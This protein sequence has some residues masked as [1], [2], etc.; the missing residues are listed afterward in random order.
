MKEF[1]LNYVGEYHIYGEKGVIALDET[2]DKYVLFKK[3]E[4]CIHEFVLDRKFVEEYDFP[5]D[6]LD[7]VIATA[8]DVAYELKDFT[9]VIGVVHSLDYCDEV[10][11]LVE[12]G[13]VVFGGEIECMENAVQDLKRLEKTYGY[14]KLTNSELTQRREVCRYFCSRYDECKVYAE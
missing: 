10:D 2:N 4:D 8:I 1:K 14:D 7:D 13:T 3:K 12:E 5:H 11:K 6:R 9:H